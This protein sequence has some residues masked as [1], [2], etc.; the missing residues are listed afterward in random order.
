MKT[1]LKDESEDLFL[2]VDAM[3]GVPNQHIWEAGL[4][5]VHCEEGRLFYDLVEQ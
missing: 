5:K 4:K 2:L 3:V 1:S